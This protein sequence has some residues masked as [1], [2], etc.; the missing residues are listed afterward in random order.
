MSDGG[1][2]STGDGNPAATAEGSPTS[3]GEGNPDSTGVA[4]SL[5]GESDSV[6]D[7]VGIYLRGLFMGAADTVPGISGGTIALVTG[8]YE[9]LITAITA[10]DPR[11]ARHLLR[12]HRAAGR[13]DLVDV[14]DRVDAPFLAAL[15]LGIV[16][17]VVT[18]ARVIETVAE[19]HPGALG[20]F[21]FGL[22]AA[23][24]VVLYDD[25]DLATPGRIAVAVGGAGGAFLVA[26]VTGTSAPHALPVLF[27]AGAIAVCAMVLP[28][29]SGA[30]LLILVGQY[31]FMIA[32]LNSFTGGLAGVAGGG[33]SGSLAGPATR[34][35]VFVAGAVVGL[36][37]V[38]HA[39]RWAFEHYRQATLAFLVSL[40]VG[41][42]RLPARQV[43]ANVEPTPESAWPA[44]LA[45]LVG[46]AGIWLFDRYTDDLEYA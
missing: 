28:G 39:I 45:G 26:G 5:P 29:V 24:A 2:G 4:E 32:T 18:I 40:M 10:V 35:G 3:T 37:T 6:G 38:A 19:Q 34:V 25:V 41:G 33:P 1:P 46:A 13:R 9:R 16:T 14:L 42:L 20:A 21:F 36:L 7:L 17:A 8:I 27:L 30:F 43:H 12:V 44:L 31:E 15:G 22:I 11:D 23:T